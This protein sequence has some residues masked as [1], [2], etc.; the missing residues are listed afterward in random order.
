MSTWNQRIILKTLFERYS[1]YGYLD[2]DNLNQVLL[3]LSNPFPLPFEH[4]Y[5]LK[6]KI[7]FEEFDD[8][9]RNC[10]FPKKK[11]WLSS[12]KSDFMH[13]KNGKIEL[14]RLYHKIKHL[15]SKL[16]FSLISPEQ[17][18]FEE[19][20]EILHLDDIIEYQSSLSTELAQSPIISYASSLLKKDIEFSSF[21]LSES[22]MQYALEVKMLGLS[23]VSSYF[24]K[25]C[26]SKF[27]FVFQLLPGSLSDII[28]NI[29][30]QNVKFRVYL[31][32]SAIYYDSFIPL[33]ELLF[34]RKLSKYKIQLQPCNKNSSEIQLSFIFKDF[35]QDQF[36]FVH[37]FDAFQISLRATQLGILKSSG[38]TYYK[39][40][41]VLF[42]AHPIKTFP[43]VWNCKGQHV[44]IEKLLRIH[45]MENFG[46]ANQKFCFN[47]CMS[48]K[49]AL[50]KSS[51]DIFTKL[52]ACETQNLDFEIKNNDWN[53]QISLYI[54]SIEEILQEKR[55]SRFESVLYAYGLPLNIQG[56][57]VMGW[58]NGYP[59]AILLKD[60]TLHGYN[61]QGSESNIGKLI[62][63][64][65]FVLSSKNLSFFSGTT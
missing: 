54:R 47:P 37:I 8:F 16:N 49:S 21:E 65:C 44:P 31:K 13:F 5:K 57:I 1:T 10:F 28:S 27:K 14:S 22:S 12:F 4:S 25:N 38:S 43:L 36:K 29:Y 33:I 42:N 26:N 48:N 63:E 6:D 51:L 17:L 9:I 15:I 3:D 62:D 55:I 7:N 60:K 45:N 2:H 41:E 24:C 59:T 35:T 50:D 39:K 19:L 30:T 61:F 11:E 58:K 46:F 23:H 40:L 56:E 18:K 64:I 34:N 32:N 20:L 52:K 53:C